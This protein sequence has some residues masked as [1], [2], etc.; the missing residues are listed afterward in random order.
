MGGAITIASPIQTPP[1]AL[2]QPRARGQLR[3]SSV[4]APTGSRLGDLHQSG[5]SRLLFPRAVARGEVL[6]TCINTAGGITGGDRFDIRARAGA[7]SRLTLTTQA[8]ERIYRTD[9]E[10]LGHMTT[11]LEVDAGARLD[12]LPQETILFDRSALRRRLEISIAKDATL[13]AVEPLVFGRAAMGEHLR[14]VTLFDRIRLRRGDTL[15]FA[16]D[17]RITGDA[18]ALLALDHT[19]AGAGAG[20]ALIFAAP[21]AERTLDTLRAFLP[22][23]GGASAIRPGLIFARLMAEDSFALRRHLIPMIEALR[24][25]P[26]PRT[27]ML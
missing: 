23:T 6:A 4:A 26:L 2:S 21:E 17:T 25:A 12:W 13:L 19:A 22:E 5:S 20:A 7:G 10:S 15:I 9:N 18:E 24:G 8:A 16:D 11:H 27:W 3:V 14:Q 1:G